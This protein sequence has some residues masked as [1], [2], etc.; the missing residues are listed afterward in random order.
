[1]LFLSTFIDLRTRLCVTHCYE[2]VS[3]VSSVKCLRVYTFMYTHICRAAM[4]SDCG[5]KEAPGAPPDEAAGEA[6]KARNCALKGAYPVEDTRHET[7][8]V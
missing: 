7:T 8:D 3:G 1:M 4:C 5:E 6:Q 2:K